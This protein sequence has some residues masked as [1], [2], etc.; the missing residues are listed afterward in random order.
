LNGFQRIQA[1]LNGEQPD[2][3][4][5]MLHIFM[6][7]ARDAG[8]TMA[9]FR[10]DPEIMADSFIRSVEKYGYD[11]ILFDVD[12]VTLAEAVGVPVEFPEDDPATSTVGCL[13]HL[14][15]VGDLPDLNISRHPR[16]EIWLEA[17]N[18]LK[19]HFKH[20]VYVR[21]NCDQAPFSLASMMRSPQE[22]FMDLISDPEGAH[23]L[24]DYCS[25]AANQF[26]ELMVGTGADMLSNGDSPAGPE[27]ISP[28]MY[29]EF[30]L[31][32]EKRVVDYA[33]SHGLPYALHICGDTGQIL[34]SMLESGADALE[35][36]YRTDPRDAL[37][38]MTGKSV[39][40][41]NID[42]VNVLARGSVAD[43]EQATRN[44]LEIFN[45]TPEFILNAGCAIPADTPA[46]NIHA[47][48]RVAREY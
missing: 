29:A 37:A 47:L 40:I 4:P 18:L 36:D 25:K 24:L 46:E 30:A 45:N 22:W 5:V 43:V 35:L 39:F 10:S 27:L 44:L 32:Y 16:I 8:Y 19:S 6:H 48:V 42:P 31:P 38:V 20:E 2:R 26:I 41:G 21:G 1:V 33:H 3:T 7:A 13:D 34:G 17:V 14:N 23:V 15:A 12:T 11:G 28:D 9:Q